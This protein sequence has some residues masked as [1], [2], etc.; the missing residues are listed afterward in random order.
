MAIAIHSFSIPIEYCNRLY[1]PMWIQS[2][3]ATAIFV[4]IS[5]NWLFQWDDKH[6]MNRVIV[7]SYNCF[8]FLRDNTYIL[9]MFR[10]FS[11]D[12]TG[13]KLGPQLCGSIFNLGD[14]HGNHG[15]IL[16][17]FQQMFAVAKRI[18]GLPEKTLVEIDDEIDGDEQIITNQTMSGWKHQ[19]NHVYVVTSPWYQ[20][21]K[22]KKNANRSWSCRCE[23]GQ[24][25]ENNSACQQEWVDS[26][27]A[28][29]FF[30]VCTVKIII[31]YYIWYR[32][33]G[34]ANM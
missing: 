28:T 34:R 3:I 5:Y 30:Y 12:E 10:C 31:Y 21:G 2:K 6:S 4:S 27:G 15:T 17:W 33:R 1:D 25:L 16:S 9:K 29:R 24:M 18:W 26:A 11:T 32:D 19:L 8:F 7:I 22:T 13:M 23:T 20:H 14:Y